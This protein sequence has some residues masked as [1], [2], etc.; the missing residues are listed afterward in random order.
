MFVWDI[1]PII[2]HGLQWSVLRAFREKYFQVEGCP[3]GNNF[4][5]GL[6]TLFG[7]YFEHLHY[8]TKP[9]LR[10]LFARARWIDDTI[11]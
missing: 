6:M 11:A 10:R 5:V 3:Q 2:L 1:I 8:V 9:F 4:I 7:N